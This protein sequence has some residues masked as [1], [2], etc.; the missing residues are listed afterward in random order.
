[1]A[2]GKS[3]K[4]RAQTNGT[5]NNNNA[6]VAVKPAQEIKNGGMESS[7]AESDDTEGTDDRLSEDENF[8]NNLMS[9]R[10]ATLGNPGHTFMHNFAPT[11]DISVSLKF[12]FCYSKTGILTYMYFDP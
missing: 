9:I 2:S 6:R 7:G 12:F 10:N 8:V 11:V 1:M 4:Q 5:S 3:N